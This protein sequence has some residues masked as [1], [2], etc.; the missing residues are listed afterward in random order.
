MIIFICDVLIVYYIGKEYIRGNILEFVK[1]YIFQI[2]IVGKMSNPR[3]Y[4]QTDNRLHVI[5]MFIIKV[6]DTVAKDI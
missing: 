6:R 5:R 4:D 2:G 1:I 3:F